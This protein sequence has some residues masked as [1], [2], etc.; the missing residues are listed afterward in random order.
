MS[1]LNEVIFGQVKFGF[2]RIWQPLATVVFSK[3]VQYLL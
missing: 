3:P 1:D 2:S